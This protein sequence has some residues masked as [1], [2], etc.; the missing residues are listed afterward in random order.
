M[1]HEGPRVD[2]LPTPVGGEE[3]HADVH[4]AIAER[5]DPP[6]AGN[7]VA[8]AVADVEVGFDERLVVSGG[9]VVATQRHAHR[10]RSVTAGAERAPEPRVGPVGH[11]HVAR[12]D[13]AD[14][15]RRLVLHDGPHARGEP[16]AVRGGNGHVED[17]LDGL[18]AL[19]HGGPGFGC[20]CVDHRI[21]VMAG[22]DVAVRRERGVL[23]PREVEHHP[24]R[25][26]PETCV[27]VGA[28]Q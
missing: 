8:F 11:D 25:V 5:K 22:D 20:P 21:E 9:G 27:A 24:E 7:H 28:D 4:P 19:P 10:L 1:L 14:H 18:G 15:T 2:P 12:P 26:G 16:G 3:P 23:G 17:R 6:V 13:L